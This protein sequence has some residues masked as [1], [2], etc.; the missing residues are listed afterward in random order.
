VRYFEVADRW[1][2]TAW[3]QAALSRLRQARGKETSSSGSPA[4]A[5]GDRRAAAGE[6]ERAAA[7]YE[8]AIRQGAASA[9]AHRKLGHAH[10]NRAVEY[11]DEYWQEY[12]RALRKFVPA[13]NK[14]VREYNAAVARRNRKAMAAA[15]RR[16]QQAQTAFAPARALSQ[17]GM[18]RYERARGAFARALS[19]SGGKDLDSE[20]HLALACSVV[21]RLAE[22]RQALA[23]AEGILRRYA[24]RTTRDR[25]LYLFA[26]TLRGHTRGLLRGRR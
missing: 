23:R 19:R 3:S 18:S 9:A 5:E 17:K 10:F 11:Q 1:P 16:M 25:M 20:V 12:A 21:P 8:S 7:S 2:G 24:P 14:A 15:R 26:Q 22:Q 13:Y 6:Y 4:L